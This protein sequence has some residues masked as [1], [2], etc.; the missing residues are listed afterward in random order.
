M[1]CNIEFPSVT[2]KAFREGALLIL[3]YRKCYIW[4][5]EDCCETAAACKPLI[6]QIN[7]KKKNRRRKMKAE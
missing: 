2:K 7:E 5:D 4:K 1:K 6:Q 3:F